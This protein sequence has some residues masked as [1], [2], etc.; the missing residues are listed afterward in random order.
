M[1]THSLHTPG[2]VWVPRGID[3]NYLFQR[4]NEYSFFHPMPSKEM[5]LPAVSGT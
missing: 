1:Y 5:Q 2:P 4:I 3:H